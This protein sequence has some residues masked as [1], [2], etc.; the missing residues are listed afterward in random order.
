MSFHHILYTFTAKAMNFE[1]AQ[2]AQ[3]A[4]RITN[5]RLI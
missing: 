4:Q 1:V 3:R 5:E 2:M